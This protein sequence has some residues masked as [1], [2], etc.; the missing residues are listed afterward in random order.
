MNEKLKK[1]E[2]ELTLSKAKRLKLDQEL[3]YKV[4]IVEDK[5]GELSILRNQLMIWQQILN[6]KT[7]CL[8]QQQQQLVSPLADISFYFLVF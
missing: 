4:K 2:T 6:E 1:L 5:K 3:L 7:A 8:R